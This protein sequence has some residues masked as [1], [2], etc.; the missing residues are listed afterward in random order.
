MAVEI[1]EEEDAGDRELQQENE[2]IT[3]SCSEEDNVAEEVLW[4]QIEL[5][6]R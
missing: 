3:V 4:T 1:V 6:E 2:R 5:A